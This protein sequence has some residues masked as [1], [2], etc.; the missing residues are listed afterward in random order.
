M[1]IIKTYALSEKTL[2]KDIDKFIKDA[3]KGAY[4]YDYKH[5]QEGL[6][7]LKA[8][9]RMIEQ[10]V[11]KANYSEAID[12]YEKLFAFLFQRD[13]DY[14]NYEDIIGKFTMEKY[15]GNYFYALIQNKEDVFKKYL[16]Y[17]KLTDEYYFESAFQ[18]INVNLSEQELR[19]FIEEV[20]ERLKTVQTGEYCYYELAD[21]LVNYYKHKDQTKYAEL[22]EKYKDFVEE[23]DAKESKI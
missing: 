19:E 10:E 16:E 5:D 22:K 3:K 14:F 15:V 1:K 20:E 2:S 7:I 6:K 23:E 9:F 8:Y 12:A 4:Q 21:N 13:Y 18:T 17:L 11:K